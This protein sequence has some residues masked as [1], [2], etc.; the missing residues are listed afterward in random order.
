MWSDLRYRMRAILRRRSME[1]E[2][3]EELRF[4]LEQHAAADE[5]AGLSQDEAHRRARLAFGGVDLAKE[6]SRDGRGVQLADILVRDLRLA[7]RTLRKSPG[8]TLV[9]LVSLTLGIGANTAMFQLFD[10]LALR[11]L[12]IARPEQLVEIRLSDADLDLA[13]G[14]FQRY[15][16]LT[17]PLWER[18]RERQD[19][20]STVFAWADDGFNLSPAGEARRARGLWVSG[21]F[22]PALAVQPV[23][24]RV[25]GPADDRR[26]CGLAG[27]VISHDFWLRE[28]AGNPRVLGTSLTLDSHRVDIIGVAPPEFHG[29]D[30]GRT[31]DIALPICA[32]ETLRPRVDALASGT[33]WWLT[34]MGRLKPGWDVTRADAHVAAASSAIFAASQPSN[35]PAVSIRAYLASVLHAYPAA[36][37]ISGLR[38]DYADPLVLLLGMTALVLLM[39]CA[40]L[41]NLMLARGAVRQRE[42]S[43]RLALGASRA[44]LI[45]QLLS[46]SLVLAAGSAVAG[47]LLAHLLSQ[48]L[49]ALLSTAGSPIALSLSTD[50]RVLLFTAATATT[51]CLL[52]GLTPAMRA[53]RCAP[54]DVLKGGSRGQSSDRDSLRLRRVLVVSQVAAS[55]VLVVGAALF[56][57]SFR[58]LVTEPVGFER[59]GVLVVDAG[60][61]PPQ[62][63]LEVAR[64]LKRDLLARLRA[65][66]NVR[67][68]AETTVVPLSGNSSSNT[69]WL[70]GASQSLRTVGVLEPGVVRLLRN[71]VDAGRRRSRLQRRGRAHH[72]QGGGRQRDVRAA[73]HAAVPTRSAN[74]SGSKPRRRRRRPSTKS[75]AS[76]GTPSTAGCASHWVRWPSFRSRRSETQGAGGTFLVRG[77]GPAQSMVPMARQALVEVN[78]QPA[79]RL[80]GARH[81][82]P[83]VGAARA[84]HGDAV[85]AL[86]RA[87]GDDCRDWSPRRRGLHGRAPASRDRHSSRPRRPAQHDRAR[88]PRRE[89][90]ARRGRT[91]AGGRRI[92][93]AHAHRSH[94]AFRCPSRRWND[95][96][97]VGGRVTRHCSDRERRAGVSRRAPRS[98]DDAEGRVRSAFAGP[99]HAAT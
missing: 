40:N 36:R 60:L 76:Y 14:G 85:G 90:R 70:D 61:P 18:I 8:F 74:A 35:Y 6:Q 77:A 44:R 99:L 57:R 10:A 78:G 28:L 98:D 31:F 84:R 19:A 92:A 50:W 5:R 30:V 80:P 25:F 66:P 97:G 43:L 15:P 42:L 79:L 41:T 68:A 95:A 64:G 23:I 20:F 29:L 47:I 12:P 24:G 22:F 96:G 89:R 3:D 75:S 69:A 54:A 32:I 65:L 88:G 9:A 82:D 71:A 62:P 46:E 26:G 72:R 39:A 94:V 48:S 67:G 51:A 37:G 33:I 4:H 93:R 53:T 2:L 83:R 17:N 73:V 81:P 86:R 56:V 38:E 63:S 27:A 21:E 7:G 45:S 58:N 13:R 59:D 52:L 11:S 49:V 1:R 87:R 55:L 34:V 16:A 91:R